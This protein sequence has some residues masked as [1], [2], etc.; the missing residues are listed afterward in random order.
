LKHNINFSPVVLFVYNRIEHTKNTLEKLNSLVEVKNTD[1][2]IFSD[3]AKNDKSKNEVVKVREYIDFFKNNESR[4]RQTSIIKSD[5]NKGLAN[6]IICGVSNIIEQ[7]GSVIVLEDDLIV[8]DDFLIFMNGAL[9]YYQNEKSIWAISGYTFP[10]KS[11]NGYR[12]DVYL[13]GRGCSWGWATW[14]DRWD[15]VDW[16]MKDYNN[17]KFDYR[18][19]KDFAKWGKDLPYI[20]DAYVYGEIQSWAI[21]W[22]YSAFVQHCYTVYPVRSHVLNRG[23]DGTGTN[24]TKENLRYDTILSDGKDSCTFSM[25]EI[26]EKIRKE[27]ALKYIADSEKWKLYIRWFLIRVGIL[28]AHRS[29]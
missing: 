15:T 21:R 19:R 7:Y 12:Y 9:K 25:P 5:K 10:M 27:F 22:C 20:L 17:F 1:L 6:S 3:A 2:Y 14:K 28:K 26:S 13:S 11:L 29:E 23:T 4:F 16:Q 18:K 24:F 8:S